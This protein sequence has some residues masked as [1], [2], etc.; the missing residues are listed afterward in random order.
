LRNLSESYEFEPRSNLWHTFE[1]ASLGR[2]GDWS[3]SVKKKKKNKTQRPSDYRRAANKIAFSSKADHLR[4]RALVMQHSIRR[5][6][7]PRVTRK[8]IAQC[9]TESELQTR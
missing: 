3:L 7:N 5:I 4:M 6:R 8:F 2:P 1:G 9:F